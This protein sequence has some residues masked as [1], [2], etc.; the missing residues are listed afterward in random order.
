MDINLKKIIIFA[1][2]LEDEVTLEYHFLNKQIRQSFRYLHFDNVWIL[3]EFF[4]KKG[5]TTN[6]D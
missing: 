5:N 4:M 1:F 6:R 3:N 2:I